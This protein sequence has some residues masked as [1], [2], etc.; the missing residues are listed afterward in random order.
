[1]S[2]V[3]RGSGV[4]ECVSRLFRSR[5]RKRRN[6]LLFFRLLGQLLANNFGRQQRPII[7]PTNAH[8]HTRSH[9]NPSGSRVFWH[10]AIKRSRRGK[11]RRA[12]KKIYL[13]IRQPKTAEYRVGGS[14]ARAGSVSVFLFAGFTPPTERTGR[15]SAPIGAGWQLVCVMEIRIIFFLCVVFGGPKRTAVHAYYAII[16][17]KSQTSKRGFQLFC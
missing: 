14:R 12:R 11:A 15:P 16:G 3:T 10:R 8:T 13:M 1:M 7:A 2:A 9:A 5:L 17:C 6:M 4:C